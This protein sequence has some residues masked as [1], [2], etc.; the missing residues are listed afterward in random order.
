[1]WP[2]Y[3]ESEQTKPLNSLILFKC[4]IEIS[5]LL[6]SMGVYQGDRSPSL[7]ISRESPKGNGSTEHVEVT[8]QGG[9]TRDFMRHSGTDRV[10]IAENGATNFERVAGVGNRTGAEVAYQ[11]IMKPYLDAKKGK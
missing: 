6:S 11:E 3:G 5:N 4:S 10:T 1:M 7:I 8:L 2:T 9:A